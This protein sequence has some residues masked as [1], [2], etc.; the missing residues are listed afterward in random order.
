MTQ[1]GPAKLMDRVI[2]IAALVILFVVVAIVFGVIVARLLNVD[3]YGDYHSQMADAW[4]LIT[5]GETIKVRPNPLFL[6]TL[7]GFYQIV[8]SIGLDVA[9]VLASLVY[10]ELMAIIVFWLLITAMPHPRRIS[11]ALLAIALTLGLM[12]IMPA[13]LFTAE[14]PRRLYFGYIPLA[15]H[16]NPTTL[17][18]KPLALLVTV[19]AIRA[20]TQPGT[21]RRWMVPAALIVTALSIWA[22]PNHAIALLPAIGLFGLYHRFY[23]RKPL[24]WW[25]LGTLG[26]VA[27]MLLANQFLFTYERTDDYQSNIVLAP[28]A[29]V[30][31]Y[32][33]TS[34]RIGVKFLLSI[35]FPA[36]VT[37]LYWRNARKDIALQIGW[38]AFGVGA[39][40]MY[41]L[42]ETGPR[43]NDGN[44]AWSG[45]I[46]LFILFILTTRFLIQQLTHRHAHG[47]RVFDWRLYASVLVFGLHLI[48]GYL[49]LTAVLRGV[50]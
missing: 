10:Y 9:A 30:T 11:F 20:F 38:L 8:P 14:P 18:L 3:I 32:E 29:F 35:V 36:T 45:M 40:Y 19:I 7:T 22:K 1:T 43:A 21:N 27:A 6:Y 12:I 37:A 24:D 39:F 47:I 16:H 34:W 17:A 28:L 25:V 2:V 13:S 5:T 41:F 31:Q 15:P 48:S 44:F 50:V 49:W 4:S 23:Q 42:G 33:P 46:T 26:V